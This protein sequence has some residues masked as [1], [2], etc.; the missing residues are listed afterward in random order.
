MDGDARPMTTTEEPRPAEVLGVTAPRAAAPGTLKARRRAR[1][2]RWRRPLATAADRRR[3]WASLLLSDHGALRLVWKN[4]HRVTPRL[5]RS[6]QPSP[7][8]IAWARR[9]GIRTVLSL[10]GDGFG[11]DLLEREA[12]A[13]EGLGFHRLVLFSRTAPAKETLR[14][15]IALL[16][17]LPTPLL[18]HCK[19]G[20]DRAG[21]ATAL[22]L[23]IVEGRPVAEARRALSLRYGHVRHAKTGILDAFL[24]LYEATGERAGPRLRRLGRAGLRTRRA[25]AFVPDDAGRRPPPRRRRPRVGRVPARRPG[26]ADP[27]PA[28]PLSPRRMAPRRG[29]PSACTGPESSAASASF[30]IL[31]RLTR[32]SP[33]N[34]SA[35]MRTRK[36]C[37]PLGPRAGMPGVEV[38]FVD[39]LERRRRESLHEPC[40]DPLPDGHRPSF[41][42]VA[43]APS[44][45]RSRAPVYRLPRVAESGRPR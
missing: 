4:R 35:S 44:S 22:F 18:V 31:W 38:Q 3:A 30:T 43:I 26:R 45:L 8:D 14:E 42:L 25:E 36:C 10:R 23:I 37:L 2:E 1:A 19:S 17:S 39:N 11:G 27:A 15:A 40:H 9:A 21:L 7:L 32:L 34:A 41:L 29:A 12:C 24:D 20:A 28:P 6:A 33:R 16:P 5:W 13:A